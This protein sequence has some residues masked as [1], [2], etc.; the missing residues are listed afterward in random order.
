MPHAAQDALQGAPVQLLVVDDEYVR[1]AQER[2]LP[3]TMRG[4]ARV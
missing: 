3:S 1:L 2:V 4:V